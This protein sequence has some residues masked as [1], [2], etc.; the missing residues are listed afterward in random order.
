MVAID[1]AFKD[2]IEFDGI[3][4]ATVKKFLKMN[5]REIQ[6]EINNDTEQIV[7]GKFVRPMSEY[8][9]HLKLVH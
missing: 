5:P 3:N 1:N 9:K 6:T 8:T 7:G 4:L 2:A